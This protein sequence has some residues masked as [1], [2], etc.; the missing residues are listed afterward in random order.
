MP[1][2]SGGLT[3]D[4]NVRPERSGQSEMVINVVRAR[5]S[6]PP[7]GRKPCWLSSLVDR[8][9]EHQAVRGRGSTTAGIR[10]PIARKT[11]DVRAVVPAPFHQRPLTPLGEDRPDGPASDP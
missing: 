9:W 11:L 7:P 10:R 4:A 2:G 3:I 1:R 5:I 6:R 8:G